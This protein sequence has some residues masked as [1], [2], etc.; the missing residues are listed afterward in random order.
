MQNKMIGYVMILAV[1]LFGGLSTVQAGD[2]AKAPNPE[3]AKVEK[4]IADADKAR[5]RAA[6]AEGEWRDVGKMLKKAKA[7]L[8]KGDY[9]TAKKLAAKAKSQS[10]MGYK[11]AV[12][13]KDLKMPSY[14]KY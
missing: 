4:M 3:A 8:A 11:Q 9:K 14:L 1:L 13:Q 6:S 5:K 10:E 2:A 7:A 12:A